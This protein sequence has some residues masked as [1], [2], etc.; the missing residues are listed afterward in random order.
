MDEEFSSGDCWLIARAAYR[1][2][3]S[4]G[5]ID[6]FDS[7]KTGEREVGALVVARL[8][9]AGPRPGLDRGK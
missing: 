3:G 6:A 2:S 8:F 4:R 5:R 7:R 1:A 9:D